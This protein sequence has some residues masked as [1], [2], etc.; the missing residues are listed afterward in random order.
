MRVGMPR[1]PFLVLACARSQFVQKASFPRYMKVS[2][3][4]LEAPFCL[5]C[6]PLCELIPFCSLIGCLHVFRRFVLVHTS[7]LQLCVGSHP[8]RCSGCSVSQS[9][10]FN[11]KYYIFQVL[12]C[13]FTSS[14]LLCLIRVL[15]FF[16]PV[17]C[18]CFG[19]LVFV[20]L[21]L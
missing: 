14:V 15:S 3:L 20:H 19:F 6:V 16:L 1:L 2:S 5:T 21:S 8:S 12:V 10:H 13:H 11:S 18:L 9:F 17:V 4:R 7:L